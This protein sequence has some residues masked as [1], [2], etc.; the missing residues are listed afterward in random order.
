MS[1]QGDVGGIGLADLLQSLARGRDGVLTLN[2]KCGL[3]STLGILGGQLHLLPDPEEDPEQWRN[4]VRRAW[5]EDPDFRVDGLRM[6]DIARAARLE[7]LFTLLDTEQV[8]FRFAPGP[9]PQPPAEG[10]SAV[11]AA[12]PGTVKPGP[13]RDAVFCTPMSIEGLLLEYARLKD[14]L[15]GANLRFQ[16][17][18]HAVV[19]PADPRPHGADAHRMFEELDGRSTLL[20]AA[21]RLA[22]PLRQLRILASVALVQ[23]GLRAPS[24]PEL[25]ELAKREMIDGNGGRAAARLRGWIELSL[26]GPLDAV[27]HES[28]TTEWRA[29][30][31]QPV[32]RDL[33]KSE[34][35]TLLQRLEVTTKDPVAAAEYWSEFLRIHE[36]DNRAALALLV[37]QIRG[38]RDPR[39][40]ALKDIV[41]VARSF[42]Q[43]GSPI[44]AAA[45]WRVAAKREPEHNDQKLEIGVGLLAANLVSEATPWILAAATWLIEK[46]KPEVAT[47][48]L[49]RLCDLDPMNREARRLLSRARAQVVQRSFTKKNTL[50]TMAVI[51]ALSIGA[52]VSL[53]SKRETDRKLAEINAHMSEPHVA[54]R[55]LDESF[56]GEDASASVRD[57]RAKLVERC[58]TEDNAAR[59]A[60]TD[61]Y[62]EAQVECTIGEARLGL[63]RALELPPPPALAPSE[64]PLPLVSDLYNGLS[65]RIDKEVSVLCESVGDDAGDTHAEERILA[66]VAELRAV[67]EARNATSP[68][69]REFATRLA[70]FEKRV[71]ERDA[72]RAAARKERERRE[73]LQKQDRLI[74]TA[75]A[76]EKAGDYEKS[77]DAYQKLFATDETGKLAVLLKKEVEPIEAKLGAQATARSLARAGRHDEA[78]RLLGDRVDHPEAFSLPW[79]LAAHPAGT[80]ARFKDGST[81]P[82]PLV[83]ESSQDERYELV[84]EHAGFESRTVR[85]DGPRDQEIWLWRTPVFEWK[86]EGRVEALPVPVG[87]GR[88]LCDRSGNLALLGQD[89]HSLWTKRLGSL[90]GIARTPL[91]LPGTPG[92]WLVVTEDG[93]AFAIDAATGELGEREL[94]PVPPLEGPIEWNGALYIRLRDGSIAGWRDGAKASVSTARDL[95]PDHEELERALAV[96]GSYGARGPSVLRRRTDSATRLSTPDGGLT[97]RFDDANYFVERR[98]VAEPLFAV[99][100]RGEWSYL[101]WEVDD[102]SASARLWIAD[103][104]GLRCVA[105]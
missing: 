86:S 17:P 11:T 67:L 24:C 94:L 26:P 35:R 63:A 20:E 97:V 74:A 91:E 53:Q 14:E 98:G 9:V 49:R 56:Q 39:T 12:E 50:V 27:D 58:K 44:R 61:R 7:N 76:H 16:L 66:Q 92:H 65:A 28:L 101:A 84:L 43:K 32:L 99:G 21:D 69:A 60:W 85:V 47:E 42:Q 2:A 41:A 105:P 22:W 77:L 15:A 59:T 73:N 13:R 78:L 10:T 40:P 3:R 81:Q 80:T 31:V 8:H 6:T 19:V 93:E 48:P 25:F 33:P 4:R 54:L 29:A 87:A 82:T 79:R 90:G 52:V 45:L 88:L 95:G 62:R 103:E 75:R 57:L 5:V 37:A 18:D 72:A 51:L 83:L 1:F 34:L 89:G 70:N 104:G 30:R 46:G 38:A 96:A 64:E 23:G 100:R 55:M 68:E 71:R 36:G 102:A